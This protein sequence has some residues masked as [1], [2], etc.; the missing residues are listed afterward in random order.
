MP[1][2][3]SPQPSGGYPRHC[4]DA[5]YT[6]IHTSHTKLLPAPADKPARAKVNIDIF[7][8]YKPLIFKL[9]SIIRR[10]E[11]VAQAVLAN[12]LVNVKT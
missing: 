5:D 2:H 7:S 4:A 6:V 11:D 1:T 9:S 10:L 12:C 8:S 3:R